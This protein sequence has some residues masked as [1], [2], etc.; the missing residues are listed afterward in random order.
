MR[1]KDAVDTYTVATPLRAPI[2]KVV[3][4]LPADPGHC[5]ATS[6]SKIPKVVN[7][8]AELTPCLPITGAVPFQKA[9]TP[10]LFRICRISAVIPGLGAPDLTL[11]TSI[12]L[13]FSASAG[14][15][16]RIDSATPAV[17]PARRVT[18]S[19]SRIPNVSSQSLLLE[20]AKNRMEAFSA[21]LL[22]RAVQ[23]AYNP[24][25]PCVRTVE[26]NKERDD[27]RAEMLLSGSWRRV[28]RSSKGY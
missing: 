6:L 18:V 5:L 13:V 11:P 22:A 8:T 24:E 12:I 9:P 1:G 25:K 27:G 28:L 20:N 16:T 26:R 4:I 3:L 17:I 10:S 7:L 19:V 21:L 23:P 14:V 2:A 15:T